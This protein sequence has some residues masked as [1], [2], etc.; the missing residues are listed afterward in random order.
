MASEA[1][2]TIAMVMLKSRITRGAAWSVA[3]GEAGGDRLAFPGAVHG[4]E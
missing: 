1:T 2:G 4:A 3:Q